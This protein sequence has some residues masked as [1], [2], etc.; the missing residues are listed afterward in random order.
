ME[1]KQ[2]QKHLINGQIKEKSVMLLN[3][4]GVKEGIVPLYEARRKAEDAEL[5]LV[6]ISKTNN[7]LAICKIIDYGAWQFK[8]NKQKHQQELKNKS[9][10]LKEI[11]ISPAIGENDL[12]IK[13]KKCEEFLVAGHKVKVVLKVAKGKKDQY[14]LI[15]NKEL[16]YALMNK[17]LHM[18]EEVSAI[19]TPVK[20][21]PNGSLSATLK[22][23]VKPKQIV[24]TEKT[25]AT[26]KPKL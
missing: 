19:D 1:N 20:S 18:L 14:R 3:K 8:E 4:E 25:P 2:E 12:K 15:Q 17:A 5:D 24:A 6:Q 13:M 11:W 26:A 9:L 7:G 10:E 16:T 21:G 23:S 22:P